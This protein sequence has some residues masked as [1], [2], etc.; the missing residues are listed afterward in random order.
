MD[1][2]ELAEWQEKYRVAVQPQVSEPVESAWVFYR[3]GG[4][5]SMGVAKLSPI[6]AMGMRAMNKRKAG[7]L[8][9]SFVLAV[10]PTRVHAF[11][12]SARPREA[13]VTV[14]RELAVWERRGLLVTSEAAAIN[15][16]V[17]L[18]S[19]GEGEKVVCS[20]GKDEASLAM[21]RA[22]QTPLAA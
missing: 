19:P 15:T 2:A 21:I 17:T 16:Q 14:G 18:E 6:V 9:N 20:T 7:G 8:P 12:Y 10:T 22:L 11:E 4:F 13:T 1:A 3:S 5:A